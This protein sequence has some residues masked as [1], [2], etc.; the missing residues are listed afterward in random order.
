MII[1]EK[2]LKTVLYT[3]NMP[4]E[5]IKDISMDKR[6]SNHSYVKPIM[7]CR[8]IGMDE[9]EDAYKQR[10]KE[11]DA[12]LQKQSVCYLKFTQ[13]LETGFDIDLINQMK[14]IMDA[15]ID[16]ENIENDSLYHLYSLDMGYSLRN[17]GLEWSRK[18]AFKEVMALYD[19]N[20]KDK[21]ITIRKNFGVKILLW[22][23]QYLELIEEKQKYD[24]TS[25]KVVFYGT[26]KAHEFYFLILISKLGC[27]VLYINPKEDIRF[28]L[29]EVEQF[30]N[31]IKCKKVSHTDI[32]FPVNQ[33][34]DKNEMQPV[35]PQNINH[36]IS[37]A[38]SQR[39][40]SYEELAQIAESI[41]MINVYNTDNQIIG[42]GSGI[43]IHKNGFIITNFHVVNGGSVFGIFFEND[44][45]EYFAYGIH[46][47]HVDFDL[48]LIKVDRSANPVRLKTK[49]LVRGQKIV[50]IGSPM[51]L[52]NTIS[53]GI[54]SGFRVLNNTKMVQITA[55]ISPG[56]SGGALIDLYGNLVGVTTSGFE[57]QNLNLAVPAE[58]IKLF[59]Q[60][61]I[62]NK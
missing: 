49:E 52:I 26:I 8:Y 27:D 23:N 46:K 38:T 16:L 50:A 1:K 40:K 61:I 29:N 4:F 59:A 51:G 53:E 18:I 6:T 14:G 45:K 13:G 55:P 7:F 58:S 48:A 56:S 12:F 15:Y 35:P 28:T 47:Y 42:H 2:P 21:N 41:V 30:S 31:I 39:E 20:N 62:E 33:L 19:R 57:G 36:P 60:N 5:D 17:R 24:T 3:S 10:I 43:V 9:S 25:T 44:N 32:P 37:I 11:L 22:M 34:I 54:V